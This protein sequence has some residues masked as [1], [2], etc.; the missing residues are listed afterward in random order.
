MSRNNNSIVRVSS[1]HRLPLALHPK[2]ICVCVRVCVHTGEF[3]L[4]AVYVCVSVN[5]SKRY[6][7][8]GQ[9]TDRA[10]QSARG[11]LVTREN[12]RKREAETKKRFVWIKFASAAG[13]FD[14]IA[15]PQSPSNPSPP[16]SQLI[17]VAYFALPS[18][19][20][21]VWSAVFKTESANVHDSQYKWPRHTHTLPH[22]V[23]ALFSSSMCLWVRQYAITIHKEGQLAR[24]CLV[25]GSRWLFFHIFPFECVH[26][27]LYLSVCVGT[28]IFVSG[29]SRF[30]PF[31]LGGRCFFC[32]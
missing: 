20:Y 14:E 32:V 25:D 29:W 8:K 30:N 5:G 11:T 16:V 3:M 10:D 19:D 6:V 24:S 12:G 2:Q 4:V 17:F 22:F 7:E 15:L 21:G 26:L 9:R 23:V 27:C 18:Q 1:G 31:P 28:N 13:C